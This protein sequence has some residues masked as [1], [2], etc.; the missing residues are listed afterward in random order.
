MPACAAHPPVYRTGSH[1]ARQAGFVGDDMTLINLLLWL[2]LA[3]L[4]AL[5]PIGCIMTRPNKKDATQA[6]KST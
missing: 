5:V 6:D 2:N 3:A 1:S 4:L